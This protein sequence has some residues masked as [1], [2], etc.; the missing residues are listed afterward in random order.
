MLKHVVRYSDARDRTSWR[1]R[2]VPDEDH[3]VTFL[4]D[5]VRPRL[6]DDDHGRMIAADLEA[7][8]TTDFG[9]Q[10]LQELLDAE[11]APLS[12]EI[13]EALAETLLEEEHGVVWPWNTNRDKR[14][15]KASLPGKDLIGFIMRDGSPTFLFGEV[16]TSSD[17]NCP[18]N[19]MYGDKG[20]PTQLVE[21]TT[22]RRLQRTLIDWLHPRCK[23]TENWD[24]F[25]GAA[26]KFLASSGTDIV[27]WGVLVRD[28]PPN[29]ADLRTRGRYLGNQI[30]ATE[31][32]L[33]AWYFPVPVAEWPDSFAPD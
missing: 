6:E 7:L 10:F 30:L 27:L 13:G 8:A 21:T 19:V 1:G 20:M 16:K 14:A 2:H 22:S 26:T 15:P 33:D 5:R 9:H 3:F 4:N 17:V 12:W 25:E 32:Q 18:P 11:D 29:E 31:V 23:G 28:T 24:M